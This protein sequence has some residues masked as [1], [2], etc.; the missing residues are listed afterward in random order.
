M[1]DISAVIG[2]SFIAETTAQSVDLVETD[3]ANDMPDHVPGVA[4]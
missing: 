1:G 4:E 3:M 2:Y